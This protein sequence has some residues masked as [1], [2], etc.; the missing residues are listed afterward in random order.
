MALAYAQALNLAMP[1]SDG[2]LDDRTT[3]FPRDCFANIVPVF[4]AAT[5][6]QCSF[7][8]SQY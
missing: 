4:T 5:R 1:S 2:V 3:T 6:V 8:N 7:F